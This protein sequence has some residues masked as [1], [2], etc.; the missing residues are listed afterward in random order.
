M[1]GVQGNAVALT[2]TSEKGMQSPG[3]LEGGFTLQGH[4]GSARQ[5]VEFDVC[6]AGRR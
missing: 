6:A 1:Y 4:W 2:A 5:M 3:A